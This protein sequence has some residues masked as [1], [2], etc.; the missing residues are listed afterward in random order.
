M[1]VPF[2][3]KMKDKDILLP[4]K[5]KFRQAIESLRYIHTV[6]QPGIMAAVNMLSRKIATLREKDCNLAK[7][8]IS[9]VNCNNNLC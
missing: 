3:K 7:R 2:R 6:S 8:A 9:Y 4:N 5:T 1:T